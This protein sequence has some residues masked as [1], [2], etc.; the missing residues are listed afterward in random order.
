MQCCLIID[1]AE[2]VRRVASQFL[3]RAGYMVIEAEDAQ[4]ALQTC[5]ARMPDLILLDWQLPGMSA[6][7]FLEG[8]RGLCPAG[9]PQILYM[10]TE[11]DIKD[12]TRAHAAGITDF[13]LK[14]FDRQ[15]L[16]AKLD[17]FAQ[18]RLAST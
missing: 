9:G 10:M 15:T 4:Q 13:L 8:L 5:T 2:L 14:P 17:Q 7:E 6:H 16:T 3:E 12:L 1:D 11:F 18:A